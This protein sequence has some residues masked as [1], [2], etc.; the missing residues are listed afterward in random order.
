[1]SD[2]CEHIDEAGCGFKYCLEE[3]GM[4]QTS[5]IPLIDCI[6]KRAKEARLWST[7][8]ADDGRWVEDIDFQCYDSEKCCLSA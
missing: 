4:A 3:L 5:V 7:A 6:G 1:M 2:A 8:L